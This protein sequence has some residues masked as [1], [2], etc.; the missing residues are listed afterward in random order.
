MKKPRKQHWYFMFFALLITLSLSLFGCGGGGGSATNTGQT[1]SGVAA[2]GAPV[3]G[4]AYLK[5]SSGKTL[6]PNDIAS[7]GSFSFDVTGLTPPFFLKADGTVGGSSYDLVSAAVG[8][9][10]A[11]INPLTNLAVASAAGVNDPAACYNNPSACNSNITQANLDTAIA[12]I[13]HMLQPLLTAYNADVNPISSPYTANNTGLDGVFDV[14][15]VSL[16]TSNGSV[17][18]TDKTT[19]SN[20]GTATTTTMGSN[21]ISAVPSTQTLTDIQGIAAMLSNFATTVNSKGANLSANDLDPYFATNFGVSN[22]YDRTQAIE[23][24]VQQFSS[25]KQQ[26]TNITGLTIIAKNGSGDYEISYTTHMSDGSYFQMDPQQ[27]DISF[28]VTKENGSWKFTGNG[29]YSTVWALV[30]TEREVAVNNSV[31]TNSGIYLEVD[32]P[33]NFGIQNAVVTGPGLPAGGVQLTLNYHPMV[34]MNDAT[35][36]QIPD[37]A[38]YTFAVYNGTGLVETR[39]ITVPKRPFMSSELNGIFPTLGGVTSHLL[40]AANIGGTFTFSYT[41]ATAYSTAG[42][43]SKFEFYDNNGDGA[44]FG[45]NLMLNKTSASYTTTSPTTWTPTGAELSLVSS[46]AFGREMWYTWYFG[47]MP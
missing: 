26:I 43:R 18:F 15:E 10:T 8:A 1:V 39:T 47:A 25:L 36:S 38:V 19:G 30:H 16:D 4:F 27:D 9:G 28:W 35:I 29:Y 13:Q 32:D 23:D 46:D 21:Q 37:N 41:P 33:G 2:A 44:D 34:T 31:S 12:G 20:I 17:T 14:M 5:D 42:L 24:A 45:Q 3:I 11:N 6:G 22:G 7:D 40:P